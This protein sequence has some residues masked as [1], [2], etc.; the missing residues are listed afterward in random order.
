VT[1]DRAGPLGGE[2]VT[3][4]DEGQVKVI[5]SGD[6]EVIIDGFRVAEPPLHP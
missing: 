2:L 6:S 3:A 1:G 5:A 4:D